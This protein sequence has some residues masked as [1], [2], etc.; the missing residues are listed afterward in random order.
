M[1]TNGPDLNPF[2]L[3]LQ[4]VKPDVLFT[5]WHTAVS[6]LPI[7]TSAK[8]CRII[9]ID[10]CRPGCEG[11][12]VSEPPNQEKPDCMTAKISALGRN[13]YRKSVVCLIYSGQWRLFRQAISGAENTDDYFP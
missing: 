11:K 5:A 7:P 10:R 9:V 1:V 13:F 8:R 6:G 2:N 12:P 3:L 4:S